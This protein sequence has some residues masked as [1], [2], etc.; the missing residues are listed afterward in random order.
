MLAFFMFAVRADV[1]KYGTEQPYIVR[2]CI[3]VQTADSNDD[4]ITTLQDEDG[5]SWE[6][7]D[8]GEMTLGSRWRVMYESQGTHTIEDDVIIDF[9]ELED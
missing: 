5:N 1:R 7:I 4:S 2:N 9:T 8:C 6:L 3:C